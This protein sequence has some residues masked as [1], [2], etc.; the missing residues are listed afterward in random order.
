MRSGEPYAARPAAGQSGGAA[1]AA[2][3]DE[4]L[5]RVTS[6]GMVLRSLLERNAES[7]PAEVFAVFDGGLEWTRRDGLEAAYGAAHALQRHGIT[8]GQ[9]VALMAPNGPEF[10]SVW[11]G[12]SMAGAVFVPLNPAFRGSVLA[13]ALQTA[14]VSLVI[15][16]PEL[17]SR[18]DGIDKEALPPVVLTSE[19]CEPAST[20]PNQLP[21]VHL[22]DDQALIGTSGSTG[23]SKLARISYLVTHIGF[24]WGYALHMEGCDARDCMQVDLPMFHV[25]AFSMVYACLVNRARIRVRQ[26][27]VLDRYWEAVCE[28]GI[29]GGTLLGTVGA[30]LV[31]RDPTPAE[32]N[33]KIRFLSTNPAPAR[34]AEFMER[35]NIPRLFTGYGATEQGT[36]IWGVVTKDTR[37]SYC[38]PVRPGWEFR[39]VDENDQDVAPGQSGE[40]IVRADR[41]FMMFS[42]YF[43]NDTATAAAWRHGWFHTGD[44]LRRDE[45]GDYYFVSRAGDSIRRRAENISSEEV[46]AGLVSHP[47]IAE[48]ACVA[49]PADSGVDHEILAVVIFKPGNSVPFEELLEHA[50]KELP[51]FMVPRYYEA[52]TEFPKTPSAKVQKHV[53][54]SRG[55]TPGTWDSKAH[56]LT[57]TRRGIER[58]ISEGQSAEPKPGER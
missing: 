51:H 53:L 49:V 46:E 39:L 54:R 22:W 25:A 31:A 4:W 28:D 36:P 1:A 9:R 44:I 37:R 16:A 42:G 29:T 15:A 35:F 24:G 12:A 40:A 21:Q 6:E 8:K 7:A 2:S 45:A 18:F 52:V 47:A 3:L 33:H 56:G 20:A 43:G 19:I 27:P 26:R 13:R 48:V 50:Y 41:P 11:W 14:D 38:G 10:L 34:P 57:V 17:L 32:R 58:V 5:S 55:V 30:V 23:Q